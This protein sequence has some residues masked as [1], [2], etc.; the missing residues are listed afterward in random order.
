MKKIKI[1]PQREIIKASFT[2]VADLECILPKTSLSQNYPKKS[3]TEKRAKHEPSGYLWITC[4][5]FNALKNEQGYYRE[6]NL[7]DLKNQAMKIIN[8]EKKEM[9]PLTNDENNSYEKQKVC[10]I[11]KKDICTNKN[12]ENAFKLKHK[13]RDHCY[14]TGK[15]R[16]VAHIICNLR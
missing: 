5:S 3:S 15:F 7:K 6:K 8:Y 16:G 11:C 2:I 14:Y 12:S 10:Y 1:Q 4:C 13:V 9:T